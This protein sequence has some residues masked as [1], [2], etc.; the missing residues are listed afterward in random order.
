MS[1]T[2][3][4]GDESP[5]MTATQTGESSQGASEGDDEDQ[6]PPAQGQS[7]EAPATG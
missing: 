1:D 5:D 3:T 4:I 2:N 6:S 7:S